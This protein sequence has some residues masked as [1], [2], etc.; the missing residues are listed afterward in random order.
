L[1]VSLIY[2]EPMYRG[3]GRGLTPEY[4][5]ALRMG[6]DMNLHRAL[7]KLADGTEHRSEAE[8]RDLGML[9]GLSFWS[10]LELIVVKSSQL[11]YGL[12]AICTIT[13]KSAATYTVLSS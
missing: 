3:S 10:I 6:L 13:C 1:R 8:E 5:H 11:G 2:T 12:I 9:S 7:D 4:R